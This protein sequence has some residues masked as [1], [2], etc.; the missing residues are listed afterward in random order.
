MKL[1]TFQF[2]R[3]SI[4]NFAFFV[5]TCMFKLVTLGAGPILDPGASYESRGPQ[6]DTAYEISKLYAFQFQRRIILEMGFFV[7]KFRIVSSRGIKMNIIGRSLL[8]DA[9]YQISKL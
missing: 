1:Q 9:T 8:K 7:P 5:P 3:K 6:G 2:K 4:L